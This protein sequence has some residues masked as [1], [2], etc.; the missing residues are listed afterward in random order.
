MDLFGAG[1]EIAP[2]R[3]KR[4]HYGVRIWMTEPLFAADCSLPPFLIRRW[5]R[6][7]IILPA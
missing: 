3:A 2:T 4:R 5:M 7:T 6:S 1:D